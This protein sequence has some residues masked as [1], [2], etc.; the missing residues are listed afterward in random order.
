ML[1]FLQ[2]DIPLIEEH[3]AVNVQQFYDIIIQSIDVVKGWADKIPGFT[4][5]CKEDQELLF[6]SAALELIVLRIAY[7][8]V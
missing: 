4:N 8:L 6:Q 1:V 3:D 2:F 5:L 7:R